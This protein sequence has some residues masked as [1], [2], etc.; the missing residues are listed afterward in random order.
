MQPSVLTRA[1]V[2]A[3]GLVAC[4]PAAAPVRAEPPRSEQAGKP[5]APEALAIDGN[6]PH[7]IL[8]AWE[9]NAGGRGVAVAV[10]RSAGRVAAAVADSPVKLYD[11]RTGKGLGVSASCTDVLRS[12]VYLAAS[13]LIV[14]C[15]SRVEQYQLSG[16]KE[17][18]RLEFEP[19]QRAVAA[20]LSWPWLAL[21]HRDG[22]LRVY[23]LVGGGVREIEVPGPPI[24]VKSLALSRDGERLA[25]AWVQGSIWWWTIDTPE[26]P[27]RLARY[28]NESDALA[29]DRSGRLLA[30]EGEAQI[31]R[32]WGLDDAKPTSERRH[33][34]W[35]KSL[36]FTRRGDWL[37][38]GGS[39]G[40]DLVELAGEGTLSLANG[41]VEDV[42]LDEDGTSLAAVDREGNLRLWVGRP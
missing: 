2:F 19:E 31:T 10:A 9:V 13:R 14:A 26:Q 28:E 39:H 27:N 24:D 33:G 16:L 38:R 34:A 29:F 21:G 5:A 40:V 6:Q 42:A 12:G 23:D 35:I 8:K 30:E 17:L 41:L 25:V 1:M 3:S 32:V 18:S 22:V 7:R 15:G 4:A 11:A 36:W 20:T 37:V